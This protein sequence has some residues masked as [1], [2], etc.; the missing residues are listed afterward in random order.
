MTITQDTNPRFSWI[1]EYGGPVVDWADS[2]RRH[3]VTGSGLSDW[4]ASDYGPEEKHTSI[5]K[6]V[7]E[8]TGTR[9]LEIRPGYEGKGVF[10]NSTLKV[11]EG[12]YVRW[13]KTADEFPEA[14][15]QC[16]AHTHES[17]EIGGLTWWRESEG[18]WVSWL[19]AFS[20]SA[21]Q[22]TVPD[23][24]AYWHFQVR[25]DAPTLEEAA[26][27]ASMGRANGTSQPA[28]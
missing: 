12:R 26:L 15:A 2:S 27:L 23:R 22:I 10:W 1:S 6:H 4:H 9:M 21:V 16:E 20:L 28:E 5:N 18:N 17:R 19:G 11:A 25:G 24:E 3:H 13:S 7:D 8:T 14:L